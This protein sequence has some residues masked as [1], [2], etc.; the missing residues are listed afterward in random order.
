M[1]NQPENEY[2]SHMDW[3]TKSFSWARH[4][5][6]ILPTAIKSFYV[7]GD[8]QPFTHYDRAWRLRC[9]GTFHMSRDKKQG[10]RLD[11]TGDNLA[12][13]R[14]NTG[15]TCE[16]LCK[17]LAENPLH[18]RTTRLDY[19]F[20][21]RG[22]G[23]IDALYAWCDSGAYKGRLKLNKAHKIPGEWGGITVPFGSQKSDF[24]VRAYDKGAEM[25]NLSLAWARVEAQFR[26]DY[27]QN[28]V[29]DALGGMPL[30]VHTRTKI[31]QSIGEIPIEWWKNAL[32]GENGDITKIAR[33][34]TKWLN[35]M[36]QLMNEI[37]KKATENPEILEYLENEWLPTLA[38]NVLKAK[39]RQKL[40][41]L[42]DNQDVPQ[43]Q[44]TYHI[45]DDWTIS[46][47]D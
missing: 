27:A 21:A 35:R 30:A 12:Y 47:V 14:E 29:T 24:F 40:G 41:V 42:G 28:A 16:G 25:K 3:L 13:I 4:P 31:N 8:A 39:N 44:E 19:C 26:G 37:M 34:E 46:L 9:G 23:D 1:S 38:E 36:N 10:C 15:L 2:F 17:L 7:E 5:G 33:K 20:N 6:E 11:L 22:D 18:K 45:N 32:A 43:K